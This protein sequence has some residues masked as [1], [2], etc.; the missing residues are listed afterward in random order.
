ME[1]ILVSFVIDII[2]GIFFFANKKRKGITE[3][4]LKKTEHNEVII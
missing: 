1:I 2:I 4:E 3:K